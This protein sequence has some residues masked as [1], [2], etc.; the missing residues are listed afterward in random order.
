MK[1]KNK[2]NKQ[3]LN[4]SPSTLPMLCEPAKWADKNMGVF[5]KWN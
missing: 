3:K 4:I 5:R 1:L 2:K